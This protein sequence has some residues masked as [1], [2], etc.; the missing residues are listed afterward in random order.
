MPT[1][2]SAQGGYGSVVVTIVAVVM[3]VVAIESSV[4]VHLS[5]SRF[6]VSGLEFWRLGTEASGLPVAKA[7][8][9]RMWCCCRGCVVVCS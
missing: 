2:L 1:D 7:S 8:F 6:D 5:F 4:H 3:V 9:N